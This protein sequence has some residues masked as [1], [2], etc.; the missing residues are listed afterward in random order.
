ML[1]SFWNFHSRPCASQAD[2]VLYPL[3]PA[4]FSYRWVPKYLAATFAA[5]SLV[6]LFISTSTPMVC[7]FIS[8]ICLATFSFIV[9][10][11]VSFCVFSLS[12]VH[13]FALKADNSKSIL[14][15]ILHNL[16]RDNL[17]ILQLVFAVQTCCRKLH[18]KTESIFETL[19]YLKALHL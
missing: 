8:S 5:F 4:V 2:H 10:S 3:R 17:C 6:M 19:F 16:L 12:V 9:E 14:R 7:F 11:S 15:D 1:T 13:I 18:P